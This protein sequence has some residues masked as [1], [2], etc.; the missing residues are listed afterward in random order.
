MKQSILVEMLETMF[1]SFRDKKQA[2][3]SVLSNRGNTMKD[4]LVCID[5]KSSK[6]KSDLI[7]IA[8]SEKCNLERQRLN[9]VW[10]W[11]LARQPH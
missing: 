9:G 3:P 8:I 7:K 2:H 11:A 6:A 1:S 10:R 4:D 5:E